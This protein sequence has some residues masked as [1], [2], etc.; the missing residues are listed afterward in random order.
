MRYKLLRFILIGFKSTD[1]G[2]ISIEK[3][4]QFLSYDEAVRYCRK[5]SFKDGFE[6]FVDPAI[7]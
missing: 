3:E 4:M 5:N 6:W 7:E 1:N 2:I